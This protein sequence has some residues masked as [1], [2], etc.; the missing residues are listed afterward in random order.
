[1]SLKNKSPKLKSNLK[2]DIS[3]S[4]SESAPPTIESCFGRAVR[5]HRHAQGLTQETLAEQADLHRTYPVDI[6]RG[7]RN[8]CLRIIARIARGLG[9]SMPSLFHETACGETG[10]AGL[11]QAEDPKPEK[12]HSKKPLAKKRK[13]VRSR[14]NPP[15]P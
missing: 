11:P 5:R 15:E 9:V 3:P 12:R 14:K 4:R 8:P 13:A 10:C 7:A 2:E 1:M 6:E